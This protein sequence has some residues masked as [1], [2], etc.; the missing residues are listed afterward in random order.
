[1]PVT[2]TLYL[3]A[4]CSCNYKALSATQCMVHGSWRPGSVVDC[5]N[6]KTL[7]SLS[8]TGPWCNS[9]IIEVCSAG[10]ATLFRHPLLQDFVSSDLV[11]NNA[12]RTLFSAAQT[13]DYHQFA[14]RANSLRYFKIKSPTSMSC[15]DLSLCL[16]FLISVIA[17]LS[18][19]V[20]SYLCWKLFL[21][22]SSWLWPNENKYIKQLL[23][24]ISPESA[25]ATG[26]ERFKETLWPQRQ[27]SNAK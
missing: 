14:S 26:T 6:M 10:T 9:S 16:S 21:Q 13:L 17:T 8:S 24:S 25:H 1:M 27:I 11:M 12:I 18:V 7:W 19:S 15:M 22:S 20:S 4:V 5:V 23:S 2:H 3:W